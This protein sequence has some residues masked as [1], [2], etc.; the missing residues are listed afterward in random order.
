MGA[1][2]RIDTLSVAPT[3]RLGYWNNIVAGLFDGM[4]V[5]SDADRFGAQLL[6]VKLGGIGFMR[7]HSTSATVR[8]WHDRSDP[9][10][11][12]HSLV[13]HL[14]KSGSCVNRQGG[15][16]T[17]LKA[18]DFT[19]CDGATPYSIDLSPDNDMLVVDL[20]FDIVAN[21]VPCAIDRMLDPVSGA[22]P[23]VRMLTG[24]L[25]TLWNE[26]D[27]AACDA[28]AE[29][30]VNGL[31]DILLDLLALALKGNA[32]ASILPD[33]A[34]QVEWRLIAAIQARLT[35]PD[36]RTSTLAAEVGVS[37]RTIQSIF[38]RM[39]TTP[40]AFIL[41]R[42]LAY[43]AERLRMNPGTR[44]TDIAFDAGFSDSAYFTRRFR[45]QYGQSPRQYRIATS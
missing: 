18:G 32:C 23:Q 34:G 40:T 31:E 27:T 7:A 19:L 37:P 24:F 42:R 6:Y 15:R 10:A 33:R 26:C 25:N 17:F 22:S 36:L 41:E 44:I 13:M 39:G 21:R 45:Q 2:S 4:V 38:A 1:I 16:E 35:D 28:G 12:S 20:P 8:R 3:D 30:W 14:Q 29:P 43:A 11:K 5:D 9:I